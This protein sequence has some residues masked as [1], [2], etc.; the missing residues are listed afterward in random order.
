MLIYNL[1]EAL[2]ECIDMARNKTHYVIVCSFFFGRVTAEKHLE[3]A[4]IL[5]SNCFL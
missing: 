4:A 5:L 1:H 3:A 2:L